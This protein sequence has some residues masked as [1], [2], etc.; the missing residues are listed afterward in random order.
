MVYFYRVDVVG[1][2]SGTNSV[3][4]EPISCLATCAKPSIS[5]KNDAATGDPVITWKAVKYAVHYRVQRST[6]SSSGFQDLDIAFETSFQDT[7]ASTGKKYYYRVIAVTEGGESGSAS[8]AKSVYSKVGAPV[9][10]V[11]L[12]GKKPK[13][14]WEKVEGATKYEVYRATSKSGKYT[15]VKTATGASYTDK[16]AKKGKTYYY[17]VKA[18]ASSSSYNSA[19][20]NIFKIKSK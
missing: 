7:T 11:A 8:S 12:S 10:E 2:K 14:T 4:E 20:S 15:K 13:V 17:K 6:K 3:A 5:V 9:I 19:Y 1:S 16:S 18:V